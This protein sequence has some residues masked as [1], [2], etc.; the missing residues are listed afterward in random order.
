MNPWRRRVGTLYGIVFKR[1]GGD[2]IKI[3]KKAKSRG[4]AESAENGAAGG[5]SCRAQIIIMCHIRGENVAPV[6]V[7][8]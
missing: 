7:L 2:R 8:E 5:V 6:R 4:L 1:R 3:K